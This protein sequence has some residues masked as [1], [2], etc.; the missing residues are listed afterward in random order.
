MPHGGNVRCPDCG[1]VIIDEGVET[2][3]CPN[4]DTTFTRGTAPSAASRLNGPGLALIV[5]ACLGI[6]GNCVFGLAAIA[7]PR[8]PIPVQAPE[9]VD[10][11][12][13]RSYRNGAL[14]APGLSLCMATFPVLFVYPVVLIAG[15]RMRAKRSYFFC[16]VGALC[17]MLPCSLA[18]L[19]G[20]PCGI[21]ALAILFNRDVREVF[22]VLPETHLE[23]P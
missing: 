15:V 20:L 18:F 23:Q 12:T 4:C 11:A 6:F 1:E 21:W 5:T 3:V 10:D 9:G 17:A 8:E 2:V 22:R 14:M 13:W 19:V 16:V 7:I